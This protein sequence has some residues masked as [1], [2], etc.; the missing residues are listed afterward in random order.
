[1]ILSHLAIGAG[2]IAATVTIHA[3]FMMFMT[4][5]FRAH[6]PTLEK[7]WHRTGA[8][9]AVIL[10]LFFAIAAE[11]WLWA[12]LFLH[13]GAFEDLET[14]LYFAT[15]TYTTLGYGDV[16]LESDLRLLG[17]F[18]AANGTIIIGW[19]TALVFLMAQRVYRLRHRSDLD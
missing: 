18:A 2:M 13:L 9:V 14:A 4:E 16:V 3:A 19:T 15:V 17:A 6:P 5:W 11:C 8:I 12:A 1:M 10:W 7:S